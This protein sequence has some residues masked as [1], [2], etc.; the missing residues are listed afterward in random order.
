MTLLFQSDTWDESTYC[1]SCPVVVTT[2]FWQE[3][4]RSRVVQRKAQQTTQQREGLRSI[5]I[6][7]GRGVAES[8]AIGRSLEDEICL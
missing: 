8:T 4:H 7:K 5:R 2:A 6:E 3:H 1:I